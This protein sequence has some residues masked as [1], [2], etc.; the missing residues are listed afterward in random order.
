M[1]LVLSSA[2]VAALL[3]GCASA[4]APK[5]NQK[6]ASA[7]RT[8]VVCSNERR[9]GSHVSQTSCLSAAQ[10]KQRREDSERAMRAMRQSKPSGTAAGQN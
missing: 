7:E 2:L 1:K 3:A 5:E 9:T 8:Q 10:A 6:V 4:P